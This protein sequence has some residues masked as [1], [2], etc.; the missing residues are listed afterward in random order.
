MGLLTQ[1]QLDHF[2]MTTIRKIIQIAVF[3]IVGM[4][5][6]E[7]AELSASIFWLPDKNT[8]DSDTD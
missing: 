5:L 2:V 6:L 4:R 1:I 3:E 7:M 8:F